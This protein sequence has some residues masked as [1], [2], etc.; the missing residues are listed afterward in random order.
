MDPVVIWVFLTLITPLVNRRRSQSAYSVLLR[1]HGNTI[2]DDSN[3]KELEKLADISVFQE[4][5]GS[6]SLFNKYIIKKN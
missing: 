1:H 2:R 4:S 6:Y 5:D 3:I